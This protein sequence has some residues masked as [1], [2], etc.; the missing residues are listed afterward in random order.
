[1]KIVEC[2]KIK[3][4]QCS[5]AYGIHGDVINDS[6]RI[7]IQIKFCRDK[8]FRMQISLMIKLSQSSY[9]HEHCGVSS[10]MFICVWYSW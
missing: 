2:L 3:L 9:H 1:M 5:Y 7:Q 6:I 10:T 8:I 4:P